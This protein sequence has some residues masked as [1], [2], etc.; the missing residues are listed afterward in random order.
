MPRLANAL[1]YFLTIGVAG[2]AAVAYGL[3]PLGS[4]VH[5]GMKETFEAHSIGIYTHVFAS[6]AALALGPF[7]F[8]SRL[9]QRNPRLHRF[10]GRVY[11]AIG[12]MAGG[13][14]GLYMAQFS[15]GGFVSRAGFTLLA[16]AW[17]FTGFM[18]YSA[19][20][21]R[22]IHSHRRWMVRNFSLTLAAVTLRMYLGLAAAAGVRFEDF[23]PL[24][25]WLCWAPNLVFAEWFINSAR[26]AVLNPATPEG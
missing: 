12:V 18:A 23:Y 4:L 13:A 20:R 8:S 9:R 7:Q 15:F 11:L 24:V 21:R 19:I 17:L 5:P 22:D 6:I 14:A 26:N 16:L 10:S 2:Y 25:A 1:L 3:F